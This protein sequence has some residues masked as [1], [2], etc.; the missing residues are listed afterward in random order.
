MPVKQKSE[1]DPVVSES[2][3]TKDLADLEVKVTA[4][5]EAPAAAEEVEVEEAAAKKPAAK[6][7][8]KK[9]VKTLTKAEKKQAENKRRNPPRRRGKLGA[10]VPPVIPVEER[11]DRLE[12]N[13]EALRAFIGIQFS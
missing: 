2:D 9:K 5:V 3:E 8:A 4:P 1:P 13:Q 10:Y 11:L 12:K 6:K 7:V